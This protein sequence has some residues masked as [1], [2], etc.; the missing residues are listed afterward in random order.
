M[1][2]SSADESEW[3]A[4]MDADDNVPRVIRRRMQHT[5]VRE[6]SVVYNVVD[7]AVLPARAMTRRTIRREHLTAG[8]EAHGD[9]DVGG[10]VHVLDSRGDDFFGEVVCGD[11]SADSE[12]VAACG[13]DLVN[14]KLCLLLVEAAQSQNHVKTHGHVERSD[15][16]G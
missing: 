8:S 4:N 7:L 9:S 5:I 11:I 2:C 3:R 16:S 6:T 10:R 1:R 12:R 14:D 15:K 13:L